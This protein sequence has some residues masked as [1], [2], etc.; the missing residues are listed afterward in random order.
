MFVTIPVLGN[1]NPSR[2]RIRQQFDLLPQHCS[3]LQKMMRVDLTPST[4]MRRRGNPSMHGGRRGPSTTGSRRGVLPSTPGGRGGMLPI[5]GNHGTNGYQV[6]S[7][8]QTRDGLTST[9]KRAEK[10]KT[11]KLKEEFKVPKMRGSVQARSTE[12]HKQWKSKL[13]TQKTK[14]LRSVQRRN[15]AEEKTIS[16]WYT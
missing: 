13:K 4:A 5:G 11:S 1:Y 8:S 14:N 6:Q 3:D 16:S 9:R 15:H 12:E 2:A 10:V 7:G